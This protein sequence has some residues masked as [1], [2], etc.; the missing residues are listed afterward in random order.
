MKQLS[1]LVICAG[2][3]AILSPSLGMT[4]NGFWFQKRQELSAVTHSPVD[5]LT[6]VDE[7]TALA[8]PPVSVATPGRWC[9]RNICDQYMLTE[10]IR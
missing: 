8:A 9:R 3:L 4:L 7:P 5:V 10:W 2:L 1:A 6:P